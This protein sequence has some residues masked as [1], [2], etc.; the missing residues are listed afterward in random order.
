MFVGCGA[1]VLMGFDDCGVVSIWHRM[2]NVRLV[3]GVKRLFVSPSSYLRKQV[4]CKEVVDH[5]FLQF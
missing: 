5:Q 3:D 1:W 4:E 2:F